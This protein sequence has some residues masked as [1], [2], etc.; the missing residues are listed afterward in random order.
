[1]LHS[2]LHIQ[3]FQSAFQCPEV[4][5][6]EKEIIQTIQ[7]L[8]NITSY[9]LSSQETTGRWALPKQYDKKTKHEIQE[10]SDPTQTK[11][12]SKFPR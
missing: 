10:I 3:N 5:R 6:V 1:M 4:L 7:D 12:Q 11:R 9:V 2:Y 8:K